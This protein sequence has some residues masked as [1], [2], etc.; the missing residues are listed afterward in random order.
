MDIWI[1]ISNINC[2]LYINDYIYMNVD[3]F[4]FT[5]SKISDQLNKVFYFIANYIINDI[6]L[7]YE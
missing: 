4:K 5:W 2:A 1:Y 6:M 3:I 7:E